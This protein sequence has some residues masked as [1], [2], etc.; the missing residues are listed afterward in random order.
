MLIIS[1]NILIII[2]FKKINLE[3]PFKIIYFSAKYILYNYQYI[4]HI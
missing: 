2:Y 3:V 4:M 1:N